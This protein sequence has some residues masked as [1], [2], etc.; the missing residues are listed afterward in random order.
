MNR[1]T[2]SLLLRIT[3]KNFV[4]CGSLSLTLL[5]AACGEDK[6]DATS[7]NGSNSRMVEPVTASSSPSGTS[8]P[9]R[10][11]SPTETPKATSRP[12]GPSVS[13]VQTPGSQVSDLPKSEPVN[14]QLN[15]TQT[16]T[17]IP[18]VQ[19]APAT[20]VPVPAATAVAPASPAPTAAPGISEPATAS[21]TPEASVNAGLQAETLYKSNCMSCHGN[22]LEGKNGPNLQKVGSKRT[23]EQI[24]T[25][26]SKGGSR[27]PAFEKSLDQASVE[28]LADWLAAKK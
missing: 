12:D 20:P 24:M 7:P 26:I 19:A 4:L 28:L 13:P 22:S 11:D 1:E 9:A 18:T 17:P 27:M 14:I 23:K 25:Q 15:Q 2:H 8:T 10:T 16:A 3:V 5:L 6:P 21:A